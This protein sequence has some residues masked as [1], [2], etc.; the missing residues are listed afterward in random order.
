MDTHNGFGMGLSARIGGFRS[1]PPPASTHRLCARGRCHDNSVAANISAALVS[2]A[3]QQTLI[4]RGVIPGTAWPH[5]APP[6]HRAHSGVGQCAVEVPGTTEIISGSHGTQRDTPST[7][8]HDGT[9]VLLSMDY[10]KE[11][12]GTFYG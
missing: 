8:T 1:L 4:T 11:V 9:R 5:H 2:E 12:L 3:Q 10:D 7:P 6:P